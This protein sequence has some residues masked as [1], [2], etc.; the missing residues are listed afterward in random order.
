MG[1]VNVK[2]RLAD[3]DYPRSFGAMIYYYPPLNDHSE[4]LSVTVAS[5]LR[6]LQN[7]TGI[8][9][10]QA[11]DPSEG[12]II[13]TTGSKQGFTAEQA[14]LSM[15]KALKMFQSYDSSWSPQ[16]KSGFLRR[17]RYP[18]IEDE[19]YRTSIPASRLETGADRDGISPALGN[20]L[21][22]Q[23]MHKTS[24][25]GFPGHMLQILQHP[26]IEKWI[27]ENPDILSEL[28]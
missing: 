8:T 15:V 28:I 22:K 12:Y 25:T 21:E 1:G 4:T 3:P 5:N 26:S 17:K 27:R 6:D 16:D 10:T 11:E 19:I 14:I 9:M 2:D 7:R 13:T 20:V 24:I 18:Y 23:G